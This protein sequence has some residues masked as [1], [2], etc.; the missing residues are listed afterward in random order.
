[1]CAVLLV[2]IP[3]SGE[4]VPAASQP[5]N[6]SAPTV[7]GTPVVGQTL[8]CS[9]GGWANNPAGYTYAWLRNGSPIAGRT[10]S[11]YVVQSVDLGHSITCQVTASNSGGE[12]TIQDLP[13]GLYKVTFSAGEGVGNFMT[14][15]FNGQSSRSEANR[16]SV[17]TGS[18]T[19][20][21]DAAMPAGGE[22]TGRVINAATH[23][24]VA[25]VGACAETEGNQEGC[26]VTNAAGEYT[27]SGLPSGSYRIWFHANPEFGYGWAWQDDIGPVSVTAGS[28]TS[29]V[30]AET[31]TGQITGRVTRAADAA[32]LEGIG[33]C[34]SSTAGARYNTEGC[35]LTNASGEYTIVGLAAGSY[36]VE[37]SAFA[38]GQTGCAQRQNYLNQYYPEKS[39]Y[40]QAESVSVTA[41]NTTAAINAKL[42]EGGQITGRVTSAATHAPLASVEVCAG[43]TSPGCASTNAAGEYVIFGLASGSYDVAFY[44]SEEGPHY[45]NQY[46]DGKSAASEATPVPVTAGSVTSG[47]GAELQTGQPGGLITGR[48][49][50]AATHA[51]LAGI[52]VCAEY[53]ASNPESCAHT[54]AA[55]E[56]TI[57]GLR[58]GSP[59]VVFSRGES[60]GN[61]ATQFFDG[62]SSF[63]S[64][65]SVSEIVGSATSGIDAEMLAAGEITGRVTS[66]P[67]G[68]AIAGV[69]VCAIR[70]S[71]ESYFPGEGEECATTNG[72]GG[73][74]SATS[75]ALAVPDSNFSMT[76]APVFDAK[77]GDLDFYFTFASAGMLRWNLSFK[78]ADVGFADS[79]GLGL[80]SVVGDGLTTIDLA[81]VETARKKGKGCKAGMIRHKG[82]CVHATVL[83][84]S[85]SKRVPAGT[86]EMKVHASHKALKALKTGHA[87]HVSGPITFQSAQGGAPVIQ[88]VSVVVR[89]HTERN[90]R[91]LP[92]KSPS[93]SL[94][95]FCAH[96]PEHRDTVR[97]ESGGT[98]P[99]REQSGRVSDLTQDC[100]MDDLRRSWRTARAL[101]GSPGRAGASMS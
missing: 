54:D 11:T 45:L 36:T 89:W 87:L 74:A 75:N 14:Q 73:S 8:S 13:T 48:V 32:T 9:Q 3:A 44:S 82:R 21:I 18:V 15:Y 86:V 83:F 65:G 53:H 23:T 34:A 42:V 61:Y 6:T 57:I 24:G 67:G 50:S 47:I 76:K 25:E 66:A 43:D 91:R 40:G 101:L 22:I 92:Y 59:K 97:T 35:A 93:A 37:F 71:G 38:C 60:E 99:S 7:T 63:A 70:T 28:V 19:S 1:M 4:S 88:T 17:T 64:A 29:G 58:S 46:Y 20:G 33:V 98:A 68:A 84:G 77:T 81:V 85:G 62:Q 94:G 16:V 2:S 80:S 72:G 10:G 30:D 26:A 100:R 31:Q 51:A 95:A 78:N 56:Y 55:G 5:V 39:S 12:Y 49:T 41:G 79:L 90:R 96:G 52:S 27:I 69:R